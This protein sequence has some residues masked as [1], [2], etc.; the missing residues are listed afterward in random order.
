L[1]LEIQRNRPKQQKIHKQQQFSF[2]ESQS[3]FV[4][5]MKKNLAKEKSKKNSSSPRSVK[6]DFFLSPSITIFFSSFHLICKNKYFFI[7]LAVG[8]KNVED[9]E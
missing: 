5:G 3:T 8:C 6:I 4:G 7:F 9:D 1:R 2:L